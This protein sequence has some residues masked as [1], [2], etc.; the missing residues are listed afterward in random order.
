MKND[1]SKITAKKIYDG[2]RSG[3]KTCLQIVEAIGRLNAIGFANVVNVYDPSLIT[4]GGA[5]A[6]RNPSLVLNPIISNIGE[7]VFNK[8]PIIKLTPLGDNAVTSGALA[9]AFNPHLVS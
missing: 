7:Y 5:V 3:D 1:P 2:A 4:V 8:P 6:L 9:A